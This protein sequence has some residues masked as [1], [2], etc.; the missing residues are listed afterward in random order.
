[1]VH[2][3]MVDDTFDVTIILRKMTGVYTLVYQTIDCTVI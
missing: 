3:N 1:M 2:P